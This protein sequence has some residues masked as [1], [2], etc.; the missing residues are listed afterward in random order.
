MLQVRVFGGRRA[1]RLEPRGAGRLG[2][3]LGEEPRLGLAQLGD[4]ALVVVEKRL[5][6][7]HV[8]HAREPQLVGNALIGRLRADLLDLGRQL[9]GG[10]LGLRRLGDLPLELRDLL[11]AVGEG[12]LVA[13][14]GYLFFRR[15]AVLS[16]PLLLA[17]LRRELLPLLLLALRARAIALTTQDEYRLSPRAGIRKAR[18]E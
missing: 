6:R 12:S 15:R 18:N 13:V 14:I 4:V 2:S 7:L 10:R 17:F 8:A 9:L 16:F 5:R 3:V 11:V 1:R